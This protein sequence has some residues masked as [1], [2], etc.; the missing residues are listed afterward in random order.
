MITG[1]LMERESSDAWTGFTRFILLNE[2]PPDGYTLSRGRL[3]RK[4][5]TSRPDNVLPDKWKRM[6]D[7]SKRKAKQKWTIEKPELEN[8]RQL[9]G[10]EIPMPAAMP[11]FAPVNCCSSIGKHKTKCACIVD[12][13]ESMGI[14]LEGSG[15]RMGTT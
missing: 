2:R 5:T 4:Q 7:A 11:C 9:R 14:R 15:R 3:A 8:A 13:D 6:S 1:T 10:M 12:A